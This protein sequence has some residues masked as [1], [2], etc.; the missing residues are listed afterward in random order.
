MTDLDDL[1]W[2]YTLRWLLSNK[3]ANSTILYIQ[4]RMLLTCRLQQLHKVLIHQNILFGKM[5]ESGDN[6]II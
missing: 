3:S 4:P 1:H 5:G 2:I 6:G